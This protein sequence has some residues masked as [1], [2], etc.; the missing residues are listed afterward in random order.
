MA[1]SLHIPT[2][3]VGGF[4]FIYIFSSIY[5][6]DFFFDDG[7]SVQSYILTGFQVPVTMPHP[8]TQTTDCILLS[9]LNDYHMPGSL[10]IA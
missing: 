4:P 6:F 1:V 3:S 7:N 2:S 5:C 8:S 9:C 10:P